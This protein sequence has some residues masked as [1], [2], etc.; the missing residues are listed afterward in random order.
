[1]ELISHRLEI[2]LIFFTP[3]VIV[4][5]YQLMHIYSIESLRINCQDFGT[6]VCELLDGG[7]QFLLIMPLEVWQISLQHKAD[8]HPEYAT[9]P[10]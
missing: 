8:V 4:L 2:M 5:R 7:Y 9:S 6:F 1:M 10:S 3:T